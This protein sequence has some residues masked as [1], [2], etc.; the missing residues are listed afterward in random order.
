MTTGAGHAGDTLGIGVV[1][2]GRIADL[3]VKGY[4][5][6][7]RARV[8]ALFD[9]DA[10]RAGRAARDWTREQPV[11]V[12]TS[13]EALLA[14]ES[15]DAVDILTPHHLHLPHAVAAFEAGKHVS[16]QKPPARSL[17][18]LDRIAGAARRSGRVLRV[19]ENFMHYPPH[20]R[21]KQLVDEGAIGTP[22][23]VR[24]K[25][26]AGRFG[27]GWEVEAK[28]Q[29]WRMDRELCGGGAT[30]FDHGYHC[31]NMARLF[32]PAEIERVHAFVNWTQLGDDAWLD[33]PALISWQYAGDPPRF[34]S[35]EV[36]A[37]V[38]MRVRSEYYVS[39]DRLE[40]HGSEGILWVNRC[41]G[42]LLDEPSLVLYRDG[43]TRAFH[44][45]P[46]DWAESFRLGGLDFV[47]ALLEARA[48]AQEADEARRTLAFA[49]AADR[50]G[51]EGREVTLAEITG[52]DAS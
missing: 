28:T 41:T 11:R 21:A 24:L 1:G 44:D 22:L 36:I 2:C 39:D 10:E 33:G 13:L 9:P 47:D 27:D 20:V 52:D 31:F 43:E 50:S 35:W 30:T 40:V 25:T 6:H 7:P 37:S 29:A 15:V 18:E 45:L 38:A 17:D 49:L 8:V 51:R 16:L 34:G 48:P 42:K 14:D 4:L 3:Q 32:V 46:V 5:E 12:H 23:S 19:F 26:A